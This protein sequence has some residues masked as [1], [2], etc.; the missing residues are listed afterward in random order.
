MNRSRPQRPRRGRSREPSPERQE[1]EIS[2]EPAIDLT[3]T[4]PPSRRSTRNRR[5]SPTPPPA[6]V[7]SREETSTAATGDV[8]QAQHAKVKDAIEAKDEDRI[9]NDLE[10]ENS[11]TMGQVEQGIESARSEPLS[12]ASTNDE[13]KSKVSPHQALSQ[14]I[15]TLKGDNGA[16]E[17][18]AKVK[19][20]GSKHSNGPGDDHATDGNTEECSKEEEPSGEAK[21]PAETTGEASYPLNAEKTLNASKTD[22]EVMNNSPREASNQESRSV[23]LGSRSALEVV[24]MEGNDHEDPMKVTT[25]PHVPLNDL[26]EEAMPFDEKVISLSS[27]ITDKVRR[28]MAYGE[29]GGEK[30]EPDSTNFPNA[31]ILAKKNEALRRQNSV[32][33]LSAPDNADNAS[34]SEMPLPAPELPNEIHTDSSKPTISIST[35]IDN[36]S[37]TLPLTDA[38][39]TGATEPT[40]GEPGSENHILRTISGSKS[41]PRESNNA[42]PISTDDKKHQS[43][44]PRLGSSAPNPTVIS[45][46]FA[47]D[48]RPTT[49]SLSETRRFSRGSSA[50]SSNLKTGRDCAVQVKGDTVL[51]DSRKRSL[52]NDYMGRR[53]ELAGFLSSSV[54]QHSMRHVKARR[55]RRMRRRTIPRQSQGDRLSG[56]TDV[57]NVKLQLYHIACRVHRGKGPERRFAAYW[58]A[59]RQFLRF[60]VH[61]GPSTISSSVNGVHDVLNS[62]LVTKQ[63]RK[64]HNLLVMGKSRYATALIVSMPLL[65]RKSLFLHQRATFTMRKGLSRGGKH[66]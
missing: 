63:M 30:N 19:H 5:G 26:F 2:Q 18:K 56:L 51:S 22:P 62:F 33:G 7:P 16:S 57:E 12:T 32:A 29:G 25:S 4:D 48:I 43:S 65:T 37:G 60:Q 14:E 10:M 64:L 24:D 59:L 39:E 35:E 23:S 66:S 27:G 38:A 11:R 34:H 13:N 42:N 31:K 47:I 45:D 21:I 54:V 3:S 17:A 52:T 8:S 61:Q 53:E 20:A 49:K 28:A 50:S 55:S 1:E 40:G 41:V 15:D 36:G 44:I 9:L 58:E 46:A 6:A